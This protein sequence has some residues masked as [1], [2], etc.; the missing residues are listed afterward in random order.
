LLGLGRDRA[1][2]TLASPILL[3][4]KAS[5]LFLERLHHNPLSFIFR[6][7]VARFW[8]TSYDQRF[9]F[10]TVNHSYY[11]FSFQNGMFCM[12]S[13]S[14]KLNYTLPIAL[15]TPRRYL[16]SCRLG[17][18]LSSFQYESIPES[19]IKA[20]LIIL[21]NLFSNCSR[22]MTSMP[23]S[24]IIT[25]PKHSANPTNCLNVSAM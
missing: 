25:I 14:V 22:F 24:M 17:F 16:V 10:Q 13:C 18:N 4:T 7:H 21:N 6:I 9:K 15:R 3:R 23:R 19:A 8:S 2:T 1:P 5:C 11:L 12:F 20:L